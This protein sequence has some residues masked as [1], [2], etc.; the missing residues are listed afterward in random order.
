MPDAVILVTESP[1]VALGVTEGEAA[2]G[3][4]NVG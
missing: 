3:V 4:G 1:C 2:I